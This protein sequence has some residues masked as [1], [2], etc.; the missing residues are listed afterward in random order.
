[1]TSGVQIPTPRTLE[2]VDTCTLL[3]PDDLAGLGGVRGG[4]RRNQLYPESCLYRLGGAADDSAA[5]AFY[6]PFEQ[7]KAQQPEGSPVLTKGHS[8]WLR[9]R[10]DQGYQTCSAAIAVRPDRTLAVVLSRR[11]TPREKV[12]EALNQLAVTALERLPTT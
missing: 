9:C 8:T 11:D 4:P 10:A 5:A 12:V 6:K 1:M 2:G 3:Q 7:V